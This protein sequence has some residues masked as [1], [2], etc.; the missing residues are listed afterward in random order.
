MTRNPGVEI[1]P[2]DV[3]LD[4]LGVS[5]H[6]GL[7]LTPVRRRVIETL[8]RHGPFVSES[9]QA[10]ALLADAAHLNN[11]S[12][13]LTGTLRNPTMA[14]AVDRELRGKRCFR[15]ELVAVPQRW[16][17]LLTNGATAEVDTPEP[18][19]P[20]PE[21]E[22]EP[23]A[24]APTPAEPV[25]VDALR[26]DIAATVANALLTRVVEIVSTPDADKQAVLERDQARTERDDARN[27]LAALLD[28]NTRLRRERANLG[29][30]LVAV[31]HERDGLRQRLRQAE[32]NIERM[33]KPAG[34]AGVVNDLVQTELAKVMR[35]TPAPHGRDPDAVNP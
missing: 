17:H 18:V 16:A 30:E 1:I 32:A 28:D 9:G 22:P 14:L 27:R 13:A 34:Y 6:E 11:T 12:R 20:D 21:P 7:V 25:D 29:D 4:T 31:K 8:N 26:L 23:E 5:A 10:T 2:D 19:E 35:A 33:T 3:W 24:E 15:I